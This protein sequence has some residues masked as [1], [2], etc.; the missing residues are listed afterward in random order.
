[1][2]KAESHIPFLPAMKRACAEARKWV[3]A[4]APNPPVGAVALDDDGNILAVA[5]H[6][7]AGADHA[8]AALLKLCRE[9]GLLPRVRTLVVTLEPCTHM[10]KT[11]PCCDA[12]LEAGIRRVVVGTRDPN[13]HVSGGG[14]DRLRAAGVEVIDGVAGDECRALIHAFAHFVTTGKPFVTVKRAFDEK[15]SMIPPQGLKT[16]TSKESLILAHR[17]RKKADAIVTGSGTILADSPLFTARLVPDH[18]GKTRVL[19]ILDRRRRVPE[20][21][22]LQAAERGFDPIVYGNLDACFADLAE[23][24]AQDVLVEAGPTLS[25][26]ILN[27]AHWTLRA[28]IFKGD[29]DRTE[30]TFNDAAKIPFETQG[31]SPELILP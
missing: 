2:P 9:K 13:P 5:A 20:E 18:F 1:M 27:S 17:L 29:K 11:P 22:L 4:T 23:R 19:G 28:D 7:R 6:V 25:D 8:E 26:A 21:Y 16:F 30:F 31:F 12:I 24:G 3:G 14:C 10:G 15:G